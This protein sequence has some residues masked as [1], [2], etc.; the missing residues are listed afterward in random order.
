M[1]PPPNPNKDAEH[2][3]TL[4]ICHYVTVGLTL[5]MSAFIPLHYAIMRMVITNPE[6]TREMERAR[7]GG[8]PMPFDPQQFFALFQWFYVL[9]GVFMLAAV[10]LTVMSGRFIQRRVNR[11]FSIV[12]S[13]FLCLFFPF[14]TLLGIFTIIVLTRESVARLYAEAK[15]ALS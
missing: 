12:V 15:P 2:L 5:L 8:Q 13:G 10:I 14:G 11:T 4:V 6:F 7:A 1:Q 9:A 3:R